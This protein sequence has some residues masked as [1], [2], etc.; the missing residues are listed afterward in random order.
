MKEKCMYLKLH[1]EMCKVEFSLQVQSDA[2]TLL[3]CG[4]NNC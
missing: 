2:D 1:D 4:E 3:A